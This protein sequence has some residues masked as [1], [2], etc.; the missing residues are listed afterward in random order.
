MLDENVL[1]ARACERAQ[2][3]DFGPDTWQE[4]LAGV[5]WIAH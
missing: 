5:S 1:I 4:G 3:D 2:H